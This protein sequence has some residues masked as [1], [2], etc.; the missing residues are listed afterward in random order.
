[1]CILDQ[2]GFT[3]EQYKSL[4]EQGYSDVEMA[5]EQLYCSPRVLTHWKRKN[6]L[7]EEYPDI[8]YFSR[9]E[10]QE[11]KDKGMK[12]YEIAKEFGFK[13]MWEYNDHRNSLGIPLQNK[14][15]KRTP[16][17]LAEIKS[18]LKKGYK[19]K[20]IAKKLSVKMSVTTVGLII[21]EENLK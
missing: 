14:K 12:E 9:E 17:L 13:Y 21:R 8:H 15:I 5:E 4:Y 6:N 7:D 16:E 19:Q 18:Y 11:R 1:M 3:K 20:D 10:W 2:I